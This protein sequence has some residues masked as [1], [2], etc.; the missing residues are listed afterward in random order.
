[1]N[2]EVDWTGWPVVEVF[3]DGGDQPA[4]VSDVLAEA[5]E[6]ADPFAAV[7]VMANVPP[8]RRVGGAVDRVRMLRKLR[9]GL[10]A[11]CR[12][13]AFVMPAAAQEDHAKK[14]KSADRI[15]GCP[16]LTTDDVERARAFARESLRSS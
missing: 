2:V 8:R 10:V 14:I 13:L 5:I 1:V 12:A 7:V 4:A 9:P 6:R 11:H 15:W 3:A 16:T